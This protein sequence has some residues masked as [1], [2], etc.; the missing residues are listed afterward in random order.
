MVDAMKIAKLRAKAMSTSYPQEAAMFERKAS[1]LATANG[2]AVADIE[3][4]L[5]EIFHGRPSRAAPPPPSWSPP[6]SS[7]APP[8]RE[9]ATQEETMEFDTMIE[10]VVFVLEGADRS[11]R[12][13]EL[14]T[15]IEECG[16]YTSKGKTPWATIG[17]KL[18]TETGL[19]E[20]VAPGLY[21][22][23]EPA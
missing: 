1:E 2:I 12:A 23:R 18:A 17:A 16:F 4:A 3:R 13:R 14:W 5:A 7:S 9:A 15:A 6:P 11:M 20:R 8:P 22:L 19:F 21:R 10:A